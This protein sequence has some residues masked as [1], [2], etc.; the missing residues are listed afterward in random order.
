[1]GAYQ[2]GV[3][4]ALTDLDVDISA[5]Y[6]CSV[7]TINSAAVAMHDYKLAYNMWLKLKK[8]DVIDLSTSQ[9]DVL[10][11]EFNLRQLMRA[12]RLA[13]NEEG[14][15]ASPLSETLSRFVDEQKVRNSDIDFGLLTY[16]LT[17]ME[18]ESLFIED[19]PEGQLADYIAASANFPLFQR[20]TINGKVFIDGGVAN[21][22]PVKLAAD[23]G[24]RDVIIVVLELIT[25]G[26]FAD[27][28]SNYS[29]Y[30]FDPVVISPSGDIGGFL[31]FEPENAVKAMKLGY[32]DTLKALGAICGRNY[33]F[34]DCEDI[35]RDMFI[36]LPY[37][38]Q[39]EA[40]ELLGMLFTSIDDPAVFYDE[41]IF[42]V[43][44][45]N[46]PFEEDL[47]TPSAALIEYSAEL[48]GIDNSPFYSQ[49]SLFD[50]IISRYIGSI[51]QIKQFEFAVYLRLNSG[52]NPYRPA[53]PSG[54]YAES[55]YS[56]GKLLE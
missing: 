31:D 35:F 27:Y 10:E 9:E 40:A 39:A 26:D 3:W 46:L 56:L 55:Y 36:S 28:Y 42:S 34:A 37:E 21:N 23:R 18:E 17:D 52:Y 15:D 19:I 29:D 25:P 13:Y 7:G 53:E 22:I 1:M 16:N 38:K 20:K 54:L 50:R 33:L 51:F 41:K 14:L 12:S 44:Y 30:D 5:A 6:G 43:L 2:I 47:K 8:S 4:K 49:V 45:E 48:A 32:L 24:Y 11:G